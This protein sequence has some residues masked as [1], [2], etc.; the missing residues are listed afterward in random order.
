M[1]GPFDDYIKRG[2]EI[3][4]QHGWMVQAVLPDEVQPSFSYTVGLSQAPFHHPEIFLVGFHPEQARPLLNV[5]GEH[6]K[7]GRRFDRETLSDQVIEGLPAAFRPIKSRSTVR[8][9]SAGRAILGRAFD[10]VQLILPDAAGLFP[11]DEGCDPQYAAV[12]TSLLKLA[13][14]PPTRQ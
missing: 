14:D 3:I 5:A 1:A 9:S 4:S 13:G 2:R 7:K 10:A 11:W 6:V 12:Q 8:H